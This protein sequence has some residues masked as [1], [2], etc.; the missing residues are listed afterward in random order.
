MSIK[1]KMLSILKKLIHFKKRI[2]LSP[3]NKNLKIGKN[4]K[5]GKRCSV[6]RKN[7]ITIGHNFFMGNYCHLASN[8]EIGNDVLLASYVSFVG[9]DHKIDNINTTINKSGR[10]IFRTTIIKD[11]VWVGHGAIIVHGVI[12]NKGCV[13]ASGAI[14]TKDV[15]ENAVV[16]G[17][18]AKI[19]RYRK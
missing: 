1:L 13:V 2:L 19:I 4:F 6:S 18:P 8:L 11:G 15:P 5:S 3:F 16:G 14:V 10:D 17:N 9:G 7:K 12:L